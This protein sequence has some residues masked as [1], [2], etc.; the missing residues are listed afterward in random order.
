MAMTV[1]GGHSRMSN[2]HSDK[3]S[4]KL[5]GIPDG[6]SMSTKKRNNP[7]MKSAISDMKS[8]DP[9]DISK[10]GEDD[11]NDDCNEASDRA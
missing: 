2:V 6:A 7:T 3:K 5:P 9:Y 8:Y 4:I 1:K 10:M 11:D